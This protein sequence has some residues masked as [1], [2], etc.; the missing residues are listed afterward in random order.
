MSTSF[1]LVDTATG[2]LISQSWS[3]IKNVKL[4]RHV[5]ETD[6]TN[7]SDLGIW[8]SSTQEYEARAKNKRYTKTLFLE[9]FTDAELSGIL[10]ASKTEPSIELFLMKLQLADSIDLNYQP[11]IN[12][13]N[14]MA[15]AGLLTEARATEILNG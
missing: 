6:H 5:V 15:A 10:L 14:G 1:N 11:A 4:G 3:I 12:A 13:I 8:N 2:N 7:K 9:L